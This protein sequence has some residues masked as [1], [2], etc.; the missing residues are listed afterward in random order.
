MMAARLVTIESVTANTPVDIYY[1]DVFSASCVFVTSA[2]TFP[3]TFTVPDPYALD[4]FII[5]IIIDGTIAP[6]NDNLHRVKN[7]W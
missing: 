5:K 7:F 6:N 1:C 4:N 3:V 2:T